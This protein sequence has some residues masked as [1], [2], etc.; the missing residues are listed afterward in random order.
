MKISTYLVSFMLLIACSTGKHYY[1]DSIKPE[2]FPVGQ[3]G[4]YEVDGNSVILVYKGVVEVTKTKAELF[5]SSDTKGAEF[6]ILSDTLIPVTEKKPDRQI[7]QYRG[8]KS[9]IFFEDNKLY[10]AIIR[11]SDAAYSGPG[12]SI[13][14]LKLVPKGSYSKIKNELEAGIKDTEKWYYAKPE[15]Q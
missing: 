1:F 8:K 9:L 11:D 12:I 2:A 4:V 6:K 14:E 7:T 3:L 10:L 15:K 5:L 13:M